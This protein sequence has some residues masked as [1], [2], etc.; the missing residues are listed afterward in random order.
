[1]DGQY[2]DA[3]VKFVGLDTLFDVIGGQGHTNI[4]T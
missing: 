2:E 3:S 4:D 1:M